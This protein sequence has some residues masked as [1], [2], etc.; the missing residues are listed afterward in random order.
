MVNVRLD[1]L[2]KLLKLH[3]LTDS[4]SIVF[5]PRLQI[6]FYIKKLQKLQEA[7]EACPLERIFEA[8]GYWNRRNNDQ[9]KDQEEEWKRDEEE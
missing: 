2:H 8:Q 3:E 5:I 6:K 9:T 4:W 1:E 7:E